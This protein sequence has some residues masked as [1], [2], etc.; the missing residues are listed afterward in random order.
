VAINGSLDEASLADV[1]QLLSLGRKTGRLSV[2]DQSNLG[3]VYLDSG[4]ITHAFLVNRHHR[5]GDILFKSGHI[6]QEQLTEAI[7]L[8]AASP[9][10]K[11]GEILVET[12][13]L[14][15]SELRHYMQVQIEEAVFFLFTWRRGDF[16]FERDVKPA[17]E[18]FVVSIDPE[19]LLLEGARRV[20]EWSVIE[21]KIPSFNMVFKVDQ[22]RIDSSD[23]KLSDEQK[24]IASLLDGARELSAVVAETGMI[25]FDVGKAL[26]GLITAGFAEAVGPSATRDS[27]GSTD[28]DAIGHLDHDKLLAYLEQQAEFA[29]EEQRRHSGL[30][31]A[32][33]PTCSKRLQEMHVRRSQG[34]PAIPDDPEATIPDSD[35]KELALNRR[36][37]SDRRSGTD[38]P[39]D[40][41][42]DRRVHGAGDRRS[43]RRVAAVEGRPPAERRTLDDRRNAERRNHQRRSGAHVDRSDK[44]SVERRAGLERRLRDQRVVL[45][46]ATDTKLRARVG[47]RETVPLELRGDIS[48]SQR[49]S[50]S[51]G[52]SGGT[53]SAGRTT[54][55]TRQTGDNDSAHSKSPSARS[56]PRKAAGRDTSGTRSLQ[57][58]TDGPDDENPGGKRTNR[59]SKKSGEDGASADSQTQPEQKETDPT[60]TPSTQS[61]PRPTRPSVRRMRESPLKGI[62]LIADGTEWM[63]IERVDA[64]DGTDGE[65]L[66][67]EAATESS[68]TQE[69]DAA[70]P[71]I[72]SGAEK[73]EE[74][75]E[76]GAETV[77]HDTND[78]A[79][80]AVAFEAET[81]ASTQDADT[82]VVD[83]VPPSLEPT[84]EIG[85]SQ[86]AAPET[87][88]A[89]AG[90]ERQTRRPSW[91]KSKAK[92]EDREA[93]Q[94]KRELEKQKKDLEK[95]KQE[96]GKAKAEAANTKL[97][98]DRAKSEAQKAKIEA[99]KA[100]KKAEKAE[101]NAA[102][103]TAK[104]ESV[105]SEAAQTRS[106]AQK[107]K[108][109]KEK[110]KAEAEK[111]R[112]EVE[113]ARAE[114][115][116]AKSEAVQ[117]KSEAQMAKQ[118]EEKAKAEAET[119]RLEVEKVKAEA[120]KAKFEAQEA[121]TEAER[122]KSEAAE[123]IR[124]VEKALTDS[125]DRSKET[126]AAK[127][128]SK[129]R[130]AEIV[131]AKTAA[132]RAKKEEEK[133]KAE[134]DKAR[135]EAEAARA[136]AKR[137]Q[138]D[139]VQ[140]KSEAQKAKEQEEKAKAEADRA[141]LEAEAARAEAERVHSEA[142]QTKSEAQKAKEQ[143]EKAKAEVHEA[144]RDVE[145]AKAEAERAKSEA[146]EAKSEAELAKSQ[147]EQARLEVEQARSH[148]AEVEM[149]AETVETA[150]VQQ[151]TGRGTPV[152]LSQP[153]SR[154][155]RGTP[156]SLMQLVD[157]LPRRSKPTP[158]ESVR[159]GTRQERQDST[160]PQ[161]LR[162]RP[163][164]WVSV[165]ATAVVAVAAGWLA[166]PFFSDEPVSVASSTT[167]P[168]LSTEVGQAAGT[169]VPAAVPAE[170]SLAA[171]TPPAQQPEPAV[172]EPPAAETPVAG[173]RETET[174]E[175][176]SEPPPAPVQ[177]TPQ[178]R[179]ARA[180]SA[181][182]P[183]PE[184]VQQQA[185]PAAAA[186][187]AV[188]PTVSVVGS[189]R[190]SGTGA[191]LGG[192]T[193]S[194]TG[195][196]FA[197]TTDAAGSFSFQGLPAG[198]LSV[199][200]ELEG[201]LPG[202]ESVVAEIGERIELDLELRGPPNALERD[203]E[204][205]AGDWVTSNLAEAAMVLGR[206]VAI[207]ENLWIESIAIPA[208]GTRPR[209][210]VAQLTESGER[211]AMVISR[212]GP[213]NSA[214]LPR[215]TALR[216]IPPTEAYPITTG[217]VNFGVFMV[218]AKAKLTEESL[219]ALLRRMVE[220]GNS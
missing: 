192:A 152:S 60:S 203:E 9:E 35:I 68:A 171:T 125:D 72:E 6:T 163:V 53:G 194:I 58:S 98:A 117:T 212:S 204:L 160:T 40:F 201:F 138:S 21:K 214:A 24:R 64:E 215:V 26:Y 187:E 121:K 79:T 166:N 77:S 140:T 181:V 218:T 81:V 38:D 115:E 132:H 195:T 74:A 48:I 65:P 145:K 182:T 119:A 162:K 206:P 143:E 67:P 99:D 118:E 129:K 61:T 75:V 87:G 207:I 63:F 47:R 93:E 158:L 167:S 139:A 71:T 104:A 168:D 25:E 49:L 70:A 37:G 127:S 55:S 150:F 185:E 213:A 175:A 177:P 107:A 45:R 43:A 141:R 39:E 128:E 50:I 30:H 174:T 191:Q 151:P 147:A 80:S 91:W 198:S 122:A 100:T 133:A 137:V 220:A 200:V 90:E 146:R 85:G 159:R 120:E 84:A 112:L 95:A 94:A 134:A 180:D 211:I 169:D 109:E 205:D 88:T 33:C 11:V 148:A 4:R 29:D 2:S 190:A 56:K 19:T 116:R 32:D 78:H 52:K 155:G 170:T 42:G 176:Q 44:Y 209:I 62:P 130:T 149:D 22:P 36:S 89:D 156:V 188:T 136:E 15:D 28:D 123:A 172:V 13:A 12:G 208:T 186:A 51:G 27:N 142:V 103:A 110:A 114:A 135:L 3:H 126:K 199:A 7:R 161:P 124:E 178:E 10:K 113:A 76:S 23:A 173:A 34:L 97:D 189:V 57:N 184:P 31:I 183:P 157:R 86:G 216:I 46:R 16:S 131:L 219:R 102:K 154:S 59:G 92:S 197:T 5:L 153:R 105:Q 217:T 193:V 111:A 69:A 101:A 144:R 8:Q 164:F 96:L 73:A 210:R 41:D 18:D 202:R 165:A 179:V 106:G 14:S 66:D 17:P 1:L 54:I 196:E 108:Q 83:L 82:T 20:D